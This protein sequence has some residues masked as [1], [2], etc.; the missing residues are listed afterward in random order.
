M[1]WYFRNSTEQ[2]DD[3]VQHDSKAYS[4]RI[5][6]VQLTKRAFVAFTMFT[7]LYEAFTS[8]LRAKESEN[9]QRP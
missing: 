3:T 8:I 1:Q 2:A 6:R 7:N 9:W 4:Q 5:P